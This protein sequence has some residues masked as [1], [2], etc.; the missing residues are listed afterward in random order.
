[1]LTQLGRKHFV[2]E[3]G[4]AAVLQELQEAGLLTEDL[5]SSRSSIKRARD[6][7]VTVVT[8]YGQLIRRLDI[9]NDDKTQSTFHYSPSGWLSSCLRCQR[10]IRTAC[11]T[12]TQHYTFVANIFMEH[13]HI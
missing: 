12:T 5:A 2:S 13:N 7:E 11:E 3:R 1:M 10:C 8:A 6:D 9:A 4:L